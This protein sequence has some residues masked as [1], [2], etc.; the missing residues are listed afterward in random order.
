MTIEYE[1]GTAYEAINEVMACSSFSRDGKRTTIGTT[2]KKRIKL[3]IRSYV[4][5]I[6]KLAYLFDNQDCGLCKPF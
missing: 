1:D 5:L 3:L 6:L 2:T 4:M